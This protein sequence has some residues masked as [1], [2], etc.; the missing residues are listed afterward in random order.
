MHNSMLPPLMLLHWFFAV[1]FLMTN[2]AFKRAIISMGSFVDLN[3]I[4]F[5]LEFFLL[6]QSLYVVLH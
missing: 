6:E 5:Y 3:I 1:E 4:C 2:I